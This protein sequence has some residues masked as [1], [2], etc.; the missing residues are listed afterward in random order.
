MFLL[1]LS[2]TAPLAT[3]IVTLPYPANPTRLRPPV[4]V[5]RLISGIQK[6]A[7]IDFQR[8]KLA[9]EREKLKPQSARYHR[10]DL[11]IVPPQQPQPAPSPMKTIAASPT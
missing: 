2:S 11:N 6:I 9:F 7:A 4:P 5:T 3:S 1:A 10:V 8:E